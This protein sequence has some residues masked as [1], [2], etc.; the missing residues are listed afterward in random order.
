MQRMSDMEKILRNRLGIDSEKAIRWPMSP[1][2]P[3]SRQVSCPAKSAVPL[4]PAPA[5]DHAPNGRSACRCPRTRAWPAAVSATAR[6]R[7]CR[8]ADALPD[9][10][11][12][13]QPDHRPDDSDLSSTASDLGSR[14]PIRPLSDAYSV[15]HKQGRG[16]RQDGGFDTRSEGVLRAPDRCRCGHL[17]HEGTGRN[18]LARHGLRR[19]AIVD[20][21]RLPTRKPHLGGP[22]RRPRFLTLGTL[23]SFHNPFF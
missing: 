18:S 2:R 5:P 6:R 10:R 12:R 21:H 4:P 22:F 23:R 11:G 19:C 17:P 7:A 3:V 13:R 14:P 16:N 15:P 20:P 8:P 9:S 1:R